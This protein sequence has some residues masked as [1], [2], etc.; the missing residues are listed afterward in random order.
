MRSPK[1][2]SMATSL[3]GARVVRGHGKHKRSA[4]E[5]TTHADCASSLEMKSAQGGSKDM[6]PGECERPRYLAN[7]VNSQRAQGHGSNLL[8]FCSCTVFFYSIQ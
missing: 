1:P 2:Y 3:N 6:R 7:S 8:I 5:G 4:K